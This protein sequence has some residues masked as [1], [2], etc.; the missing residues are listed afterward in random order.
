MP[1]SPLG[2]LLPFFLCWHSKAADSQPA[3]GPVA[4]L[5]TQSPMDG[6]FGHLTCSSHFP[7]VTD[8]FVIVCY[9]YISAGPF[10]TVFE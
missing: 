9:K 7:S 6:L 2:S 1:L 10:L 3:S 8:W 5:P 4:F